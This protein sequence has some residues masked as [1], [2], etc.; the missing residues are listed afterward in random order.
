M[1]KW[2]KTFG[3]MRVFIHKIMLL[4]YNK[5]LENLMKMIS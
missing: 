2:I 1:S 3:M 4:N 5:Y